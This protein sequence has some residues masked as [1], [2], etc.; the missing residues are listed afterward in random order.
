MNDLLQILQAYLLDT[1]GLGECAEW[2]AG[3]DWDDPDL[4]N[5]EKENLGLVELLLTEV[6]EGLRK[7][8]EFWEAAAEFVGARTQS[9]FAKQTFPDVTIT[10]GTADSSSLP[11]VEWIPVGQEL[12][13]WNISPQV[14]PL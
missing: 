3:V 14:V 8:Q 12:Q 7:E 9:G 6:A 1:R 10:V 4:T 11:L 5:E 2:L 13:S